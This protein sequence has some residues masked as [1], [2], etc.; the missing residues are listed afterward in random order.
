M[1]MKTYSYRATDEDGNE[2]SGSL[3][4]PSHHAAKEMLKDMHM[5]PVH[6]QEAMRVKP[7]RQEEQVS[8]PAVAGETVSNQ[9][10]HFAFEGTDTAGKQ[11]K[12]VIQSDSKEQAFRRIQRD[13]GLQVN[14]LYKAGTEK[15][16]SDG[17]LISWQ[18]PKP[19]ESPAL[20]TDA[21]PPFTIVDEPLQ[22]RA[23]TPA[24]KD[25]QS[26]EKKPRSYISIFETLR[27]YAGWLL[28]WYGL[29]V[30][31]GYYSYVRV[32]PVDLPAAQGFLFSPLIFS[33]I[34]IIFLYLLMTTIQRALRGQMLLGSALA[35]IG[36]AL[37]FVLQIGLG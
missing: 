26:V 4:A 23:T 34:L 5:V 29:F 13:Q 15:P 20:L 21:P 10:S 2:V 11:H 22:M 18:E 9:S 32:S 37:F 3:E 25:E 14:A 35:V 1:L 36:I 17:D 16:M 30:A 12:G 28:A 6:I 8:V 7:A 31:F 24:A 27:L 33:F 19:A